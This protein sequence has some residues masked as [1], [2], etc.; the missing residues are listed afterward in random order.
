MET[1]DT[2]LNETIKILG[3]QIPANPAAERNEHLEKQMQKT[4]SEYFRNLED[5]FDWNALEQIYYRHVKN[6]S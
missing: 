1:I 4:L 3:N 2:L 6:E 5:A